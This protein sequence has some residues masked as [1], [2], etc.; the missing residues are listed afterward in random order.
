[1][2]AHFFYDCGAG[3]NTPKDGLPAIQN[4]RDSWVV[5][6]T[7]NI[8]HSVGF[9]L[10]ILK[11]IAAKIDWG[12]KLDRNKKTGESASEFHISMNAAF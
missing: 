2:K 1:M 12:Y 8:R 9:G 6:D 4:T 10:N 11:P 7:F 3:W 5:R